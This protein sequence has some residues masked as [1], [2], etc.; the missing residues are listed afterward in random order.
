[1]KV[2]KQLCEP[3]A[4]GNE[5]SEPCAKHVKWN[6]EA[7]P[8]V[9]KNTASYMRDYAVVYTGDCCSS[10]T[11]RKAQA[12]IGVYWGPGHPL[13]IGI[14]LPGQQTNQRAEIHVACKA[15]PQARAQNI[16]KLALYTDSMFYDQWYC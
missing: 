8:L 2:N 3:L 16:S 4:E 6:T 15:I 14:R 13:N 5:N 12:G 1:M 10:N 9:G 7:T 11:Q